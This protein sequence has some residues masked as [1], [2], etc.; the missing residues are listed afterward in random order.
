MPA[1][2]LVAPPP[3]GLGSVAEVEEM[4]R[5]TKH[6]SV[7]L[8]ICLVVAEHAAGSVRMAQGL[9]EAGK[10]QGKAVELAA[11]PRGAATGTTGVAGTD[12]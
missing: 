9:P 7:H 6:S 5:A 4:S 2:S 8:S 11:V 12:I 1:T 10:G 3:P